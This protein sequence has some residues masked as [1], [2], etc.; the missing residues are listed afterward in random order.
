VMHEG[1]DGSWGR[2]LYALGLPAFRWAALPPWSVGWFLSETG[3]PPPANT[4]DASTR[5]E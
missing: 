4:S 3:D 1:P 2:R 5:D